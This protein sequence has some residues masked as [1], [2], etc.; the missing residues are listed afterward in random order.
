[1]NGGESLVEE[2]DRNIYKDQRINIEQKA[3]IL[4]A[5]AIFTG[6][7]DKQL[8]TELIKRRRDI[9]IQSPIYDLIKEEGK[10]EGLM[11]GKIEGKI[12]GLHEAISLGLELKFGQDSLILMDKVLRIGSIDKLEK[13]K[14]LIKKA[15]SVK[16]IEKLV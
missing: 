9:M 2:F 14:E 7:K 4:T 16:E 1:M 6:L 8:A 3:D 10:L 12:E 11:E 5:M 15:E 13:I